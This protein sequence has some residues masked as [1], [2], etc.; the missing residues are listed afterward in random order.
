MMEKCY[1][2]VVEKIHHYYFNFFLKKGHKIFEKV[3][4]EEPSKVRTLLGIQQ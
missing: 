2:Y 4:C 1:K 3:R